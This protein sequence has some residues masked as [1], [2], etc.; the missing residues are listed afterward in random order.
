LRMVLGEESDVETFWYYFSDG[1]P[2]PRRSCRELLFELRWPVGVEEAAPGLR[3]AALDDLDL[4]VPPH[5]QAVIEESG[6]DPL[7][8][9]AVGFRLRCARR[10]EQGRTWVLVE[11]GKL[12][13]KA[14]IVSDT[15]DVIY[16]EGVWVA[17]EERGKGYGLRCLSQL[18]RTLLTR[19]KSVYLFVNEQNL[20]AQSFYRQAGFRL[21]RLYKT[22]FF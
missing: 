5:A 19:A 6:V 13:F 2:T 18:S 9:D 15:P 3:A 10:I 12:I 1:G 8:V 16:L 21:N 17:P 11:D 22:L 4:V 14:E 20:E 7:R